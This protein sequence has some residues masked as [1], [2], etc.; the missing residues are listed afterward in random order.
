MIKWLLHLFVKDH[1]NTKDPAVRTAIG[2]FAGWVGIFC[3]L[4]LVAGKMAV[5]LA[6]GSISVIAD[7]LNNLLDAVSS[8]IAL[9]GFKI[10]AK[11]A[12][13]EHPFGHG[14]YEYI[15]G[16]AVAVLVLVVGI[17]LGKSSLAKILAPTPVD[18]SLVSLIVLAAS[19]L[20]KLWL[21]AFNRSVGLSISS[22]TLKATGVDS[23][24]DAVATSAVLL[25]AVLA[26]FTGMNLDGWASLGVAAFILYS[27]IGLVKEALNPLLGEA[28][29]P[30]LI[31]YI[32]E[33]IRAY[34]CVLGTHDLIVHDYGPGRLIASAH[35]EISGE[36]DALTAHQLIDTIE[37]D[38]LENDNI[39]LI[40]H[41]DPVATGD[42]NDYQRL[43]VEGQVKT[44]DTRLSIHDLRI[45]DY[46]GHTDY[47]FDVFAPP[48]IKT[49]DSELR[50]LILEALQTKD[51]PAQVTITI[52]RSSAD[53]LP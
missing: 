42:Q 47:S 8:V 37:R 51:K 53:T 30:E 32:S 13:K 28:P 23:R 12:D 11:K 3:N 43:W 52:D 16:L 25:T 9:I 2:S 50:M 44:I 18:F 26:R 1:Q 20:L 39:H 40:I 38:F 45:E 24:N 21:S 31:R 7:A 22:T 29:A 5:G 6:S 41:H 14:R 17:E 33:K 46:P 48:E 34:E 36:I 49:P 35:V 27:G 10:A 15:S 19:I 4:F